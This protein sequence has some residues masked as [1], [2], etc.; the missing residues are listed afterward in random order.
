MDV[1][2][3]NLHLNLNAC[4]VN[5]YLPD[6]TQSRPH[7]DNE[8]YVDQSSPICTFSIG[9]PRTISILKKSTEGPSLLFDQNLE[10]GSLFVM[11]PGAQ[12]KTL[13]HVNSG[14]ERWSISFRKIENC[15][16]NP[17]E[18]PYHASLARKTSKPT[19]PPTNPALVAASP[20]P[21]SVQERVE[22][23]VRS[24][25]S[26]QN[27]GGV[28]SPRTPT[29]THNQNNTQSKKN[30]AQLSPETFG[31]P[32]E[33]RAENLEEIIGRLSIN[34]CKALIVKANNRITELE[35]AAYHMKD[36]E[37]EKYVKYVPKPLS[38]VP[39]EEYQLLIQNVREDLKLL[40]MDIASPENSHRQLTTKWLVNDPTKFGYL[41]SHKFDKY[42]GILK[43]CS[44]ISEL[45]TS[46]Q[47]LNSCLITLY[48]DGSKKTRLHSDKLPYISENT[49]ICNISIGSKRKLA[50]FNS[51]LHSSQPLRTFEV[52]DESLLVMVPPCQDK[53][54][55]ILLPCDEAGPRVCLSFRELIPLNDNQIG[56]DSSDGD[57]PTTVLIGSSI[58]TRI[59][60]AKIVGKK[61]NSNFINC[62][63]SGAFIRDASE[64]VDKLYAGQL[65][66]MNDRTVDPSSNIKHIILSV[67]TNDIR[68]KSNGISNLYHPVKELLK[69][70]KL[71]FPKAKVHFQS[72]IPMG[73]EYA[74]TPHNVVSFNRLAR[75]CTR[76]LGCDYVDIYEDFIL[77][78]GPHRHPNR[79]LFNDNLHPS[80]KG[81]G[82][83]ARAFI[84]IARN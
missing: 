29:P 67:G 74:W 10:S 77:S 21:K 35:K 51:M 36:E 30:Q 64:A 1:I 82:V 60:P 24:E 43:L 22:D 16:Y 14:G 54:K 32:P 23:Y 62:S 20:R 7:S 71:L 19:P 65:T 15:S 78:V 39:Q 46:F 31:T 52:E 72:L 44:T 8:T 25:S 73:Y 81:S 5:H 80:P 66:D 45:D 26:S 37:V 61:I 41:N 59:N 47:K 28:Q 63:K 83:I 69:K 48:P 56:A 38:S 4:V 3:D 84:G 2:N 13:H 9:Q 53:L 18:W 70:T 34:E 49:P 12:E 58:T 40:K 27:P 79:K 68:K 75:R 11:M 17:T 33:N 57:L 42:K 55:H 50:F 76:E 6:K